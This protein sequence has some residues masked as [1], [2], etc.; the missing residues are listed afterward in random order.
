MITV[1]QLVQDEFGTPLQRSRWEFE[2]YD[3]LGCAAHVGMDRRAIEV[4]PPTL[5][6]RV[7]EVAAV[8]FVVTRPDRRGEGLASSLMKAALDV[9]LRIGFGYSVLFTSVPYFYETLGYEPVGG[10][11][12]A[13]GI[14]RRWPGVDW[15]PVG[16]R[17]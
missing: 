15:A 13:I 11:A 17:W 5:P 2:T 7:E 6:S 8:R 16:E 12:M 1:E 4:S 10:D 3:S 14:H 9:A